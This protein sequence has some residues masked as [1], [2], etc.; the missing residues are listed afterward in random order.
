MQHLFD[1]SCVV[2]SLHNVQC[3]TLT[4]FNKSVRVLFQRN[5][6][7]LSNWI[8]GFSFLKL[9]CRFFLH[10]EVSLV[11][12]KRVAIFPLIFTFFRSLFLIYNKDTKLI[13]LRYFLTCSYSRSLTNLSYSSG[14]TLSI[15]LLSEDGGTLSVAF[16][17]HQGICCRACVVFSRRFIGTAYDLVRGICDL[18]PVVRS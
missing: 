2:S 7:A 16:G 12:G 11:G 5:G 1:S 14:M 9:L 10:L 8:H 6:L 3:Y 15:L 4:D 18:L 17:R 13:G